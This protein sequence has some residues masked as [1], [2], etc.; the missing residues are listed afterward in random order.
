MQTCSEGG[1]GDPP[2]PAED[3]CWSEDDGVVVTMVGAAL[4]PRIFR[5]F[6][7]YFLY[8]YS[9]SHSLAQIHF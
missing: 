3:G 7:V 1:E 5:H 8:S 9:S 2:P 4:P 6:F